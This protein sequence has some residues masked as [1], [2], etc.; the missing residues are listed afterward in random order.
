MMMRMIRTG[1]ERLIQS[2]SSRT[3]LWDHMQ[4]PFVPPVLV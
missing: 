3:R 1:L 4:I 2:L